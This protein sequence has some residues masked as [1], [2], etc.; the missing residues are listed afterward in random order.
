MQDQIMEIRIFEEKD[1]EAVIKLWQ[2]CDLTRSWN[3]PDKDIDRKTQFQ[4]GL[5]F[6]GEVGEQIIASAMAGYDGHRGSV[7]YLAV[8]PD[9]QGHG[10]GQELMVHIE[11]SLINLGCPKIN[12]VVRSTNDHVLGFYNN[13]AYVADDVVS[14]GKRLIPDA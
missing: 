6:V 2:T 14:V 4:S 1:R 13:M 10:Y 11:N 12:V 7:F 3:N 9:Y 8:N 5:F